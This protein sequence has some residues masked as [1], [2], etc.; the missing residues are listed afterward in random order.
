MLEG[1]AVSPAE[2]NEAILDPDALWADPDPSSKSGLGVRVVGFCPTRDQL[3][4]V[5][6]LHDG[7]DY[8]GVNGWVTKSGR[9]RTAY[10]TGDE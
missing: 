8:T 4:T 7:D 1:H 3:P 10:W 6:L 5:I 9:D 2:A